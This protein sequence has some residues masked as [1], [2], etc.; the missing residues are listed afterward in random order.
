MIT[1][2]NCLVILL[3]TLCLTTVVQA[4]NPAARTPANI[5]LISAQELK[6]KVDHNE[7]LVILDVRSSESYANSDRRIKG[8]IHVKVRR[9]EH[10]LNFPPLKDVPRDREIITYCACPSEEASITAAQILLENGF[11][12]VRALKGGWQDWLK[13][14]GAVEPRPKS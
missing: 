3:A 5:D 11:K 1:K 2:L 8:A 14:N 6:A 12:R 10:R 9:L 7:P 4:Q 13:V